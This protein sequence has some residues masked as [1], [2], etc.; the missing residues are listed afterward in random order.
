MESKYTLSNAWPAERE[1]L[2]RMERYHD[3][4][5][6]E[7]LTR[8]GV[9][10]GWRC[11]EVAAGAGSITRWLAER[12]GKAGSV[13]ATDLDPRLLAVSDLENVEVRK[14]DI[15]TDD[16]EEAGFDLVHARN[17]LVHLRSR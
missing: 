3:S 11:L 10:H 15:L 5:S 8:L 12:V 2:Q 4:I 17:L 7:T 6:I 13:V 1:R 16:L 9:A 14:H